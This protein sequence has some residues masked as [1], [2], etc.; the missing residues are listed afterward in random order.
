MKNFWTLFC[1]EMKKIWMQKLTWVVMLGFTAFMVYSIIPHYDTRGA[2]FTTIDLDGNSISGFV[3]A[4]ERFWLQATGDRSIDGQVMDETFFNS[5]RKALPETESY[6]NLDAFFLLVDPSYYQ[7]FYDTFGTDLRTMTAEDFYA[8]RLDTIKSRW[9]NDLELTDDE[10]IYWE[11]MEDRVE[12]PFVYRD[13]TSPGSLLYTTSSMYQFLP[14]ILAVFLCGVFPQERRTRMDQMVFSSRWGRFPQYVAKLSAG[15]V[16]AVT[17]TVVVFCA[18]TVACVLCYGWEGVDA[19][20]QIYNTTSSW[21]ITMGQAIMFT[22][23]LILI[24]A[25]LCGSVT[26]LVSAV[27]QNRL[28]G[29]IVPVVWMLATI[30]TT[31]MVAE[32]NT[33]GGAFWLSE[34]M[35]NKLFN[36]TFQSGHLVKLLGTQLTYSQFAYIF[37]GGLAILLLAL[38]WLGWRR[39]AT[40]ER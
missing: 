18:T 7:F 38:C 33:S 13:T 19:A 39:W 34:F 23:G 16:S 29:M 37:Y 12:K 20:L 28:V 17:T 9:N 1:Y 31:P 15:V 32:M 24:Y 6:Y 30:T 10:I 35:P 5:M 11:T 25:L 22:L 36:Y 40:S 27:S 4:K 3:S 8:M 2:T 26:M 21:P 14:L